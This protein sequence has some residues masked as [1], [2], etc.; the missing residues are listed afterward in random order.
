MCNQAEARLSA[1]LESTDDPIWSVDLNFALTSINRAALRNIQRSS[2][3]EAGIGM[4]PEEMFPP[5]EAALWPPLFERALAEGSFQIEYPR[6][7]GRTLAFTFHRI[8]SDGKTTGVSVFGKDITEAKAKEESRRYFAE[9]V[10][11]SHDAILTYAPD[12]TILTWNQDAQAVFGY[13]A[14][15]AVGCPLTMVVAPERRPFLGEF[16]EAVFRDRAI[17]QRQSVGLRKD[18][19]RIAVSVTSSAIRNSARK[20]TAISIV[21]RDVTSRQEAEENRALLASIVESSEDAIHAVELDGTLISWNR[22]AEVLFGYTGQEILGKSIAV[23][24]PPGRSNEVPQFMGLIEKGIA[25]PAFDTTLR[26]KDGREIEVALSISPMR[27]STGKITGAAAIARNIAQRTQ[28]NRALKD[29]EQKYRAI[30]DGALEGMFQTSAGN[31]L[32]CV[33]QALVQMLGYESPAELISMATN[34]ARFV[35]DSDERS[36]LTEQ[37][38]KN[39]AVR[40]FECRL[41][42]KDD[43]VIWG[44]LTFRKVLGDEG[45]F[46]YFEGFVEDITARKQAAQE[47]ACSE[48]RFRGLF[49]GNGSVFLLVEPASGEIVEAN[50]AASAFHGY[51]QEQLVGMSVGQINTLGLEAVESYRQHALRGENCEFNFRH[52]LASGEERD[53]TVYSSPVDTDGRPL[54]FSVIHDVTDRKRA[55]EALREADDFLKEAQIVGMLGSY[56]LD[57]ETGEWTSSEVLD[58]IFGIDKAYHRDVEGWTSLIHPQDRAMMATYFTNEVLGDRKAFDKEYR[59]IRQ[60]DQEVRWVHGMGKLEMDSRNRPIKMHGIIKDITERMNAEMQLRDSEKRYRATFEQAAMGILHTSLDGRILRCNSRFAE[61]IGYSQEEVPSL[62]FQQITAPEDV[63]ANLESLRPIIDGS[64]ENST[65]E[66][67]YVRKDGTRTWVKVTASTLRDDQGC[68]QHLIALVED[69]NA[70]KAAEESLAIT[71]EALRVSEERYRTIFQT[72]LDP[73]LITRVEDGKYVEVNQAFLNLMGFERPE[74]IGQTSV[75]LNLWVDP[76]DRQKLFEILNRTSE[77]R[78]LELHFRKRNGESICCLLSASVIQIDGVPCV[79]AIARD[80][81]NARAAEREIR[82]LAFYDPLTGLPNRRL[83]QDRLHLALAPGNRTVRMRALMF[84]DLDNFKTLNDTLGH[85]IG[86]LLLGEVALR[87][88]NCLREVDTVARLGGDEFV[89]MLEN[90]SYSPEEAAKE[91]K[92]VAEEILLAVDQPYLLDGHECLSTCSIGITVFGDHRETVD[93][94]MRQADIAMYQAK[95]AGRNGV[96]IFSPALQAAVHARAAMEEDLRQGIE[97]NQFLLY[98]QPQID[99]GRLVGA[100]ALLRWN[101]PRRG[102]LPPGEFIS[103]AED[104]GLILPLGDWVLEA[105]C[106]QI[107]QWAGRGETAGVTVAVN[108]SALQLRQPDFVESVLSALHRTGA[109]PRNLDLEL[110]E[111]MLVENVDDVIDKMTELKSHGLKFSLDDFGTGYSSLSYLKRLPLDHLKIDH[112]FVRDILVDASSGAIAQTVISLSQATGLSVIAEGVETE[113]QRVFLAR[114]G[115]HAF[116]GFLFSRPVPIDEFEALLSSPSLFPASR[117]S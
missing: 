110:T 101:H 112:S 30:F 117:V 52:R 23:L 71:Q 105:A 103:I 14:A 87:I 77:C 98:Y 37:I 41:R 106:R 60:V 109:N 32:L 79:L 70:F 6:P 97:T 46:H 58:G 62:T 45:G 73:V 100:E 111:S 91:A 49:D 42:R 107:V 55:E 69:I 29:S 10:E 96:H 8:V 54:L 66:E 31:K 39:G 75:G 1:L 15:E 48:A 28:L 85:Q 95:A 53:V 16:T 47:L 64:L 78:N 34:L 94:V 82:N 89:V 72:T 84:V 5:A 81:S 51:T 65:W 56:V 9:V 74:V 18:G 17:P 115:C 104:C 35:F 21:V 99:D 19:K 80:I 40:A 63:D 68:V 3:V 59:I 83:L 25:V 12:G 76:R 92:A 11:S 50:R 38:Q 2:G 26:G 108:I 33:N 44:S 13:S 86:D 113:E 36:R 20:V 116:Q 88:A 90:L 114:L 57:I 61:I 102:I 67:R 22:G 7:D 4:R 24:A 93:D 27:D 43:A